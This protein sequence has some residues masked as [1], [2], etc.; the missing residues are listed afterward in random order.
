MTD[1]PIQ[2][3]INHED[4]NIDPNYR[5]NNTLDYEFLRIPKEENLL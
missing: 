1:I 5:P 4:Q 3:N 2:A